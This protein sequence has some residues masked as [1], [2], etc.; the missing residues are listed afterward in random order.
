MPGSRAFTLFSFEGSQ[1]GR[2]PEV[3]TALG[4]GILWSKGKQSVPLRTERAGA[5]WCGLWAREISGGASGNRSERM[6]T[7]R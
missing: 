3:V 6:G 5:T 4:R 7:G 1:G 2:S